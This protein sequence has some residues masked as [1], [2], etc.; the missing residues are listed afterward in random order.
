MTRRRKIVIFF[1]VIFLFFAG[2]EMYD[3][4]QFASSDRGYRHVTGL[5]LPANIYAMAH[6]SAMNDNL[7]HTTHYWLVQGPRENLRELAPEP[8]FGRSDRDAAE[9]LED[10]E[11][12]MP[13]GEAK[14]IEGYEGSLDGGRDRWLLILEPGDRAVFIY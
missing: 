10:I 7:M 1:V 4:R 9:R 2:G 8:G 12:L 13:L 14:V 3:S 6:A 11:R 5:D